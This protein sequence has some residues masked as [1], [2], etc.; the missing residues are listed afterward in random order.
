MHVWY[1]CMVR[2]EYMVCM[3]VYVCMY[4]M[5]PSA[6]HLRCICHKVEMSGAMDCLPYSRCPTP[7][8]KNLHTYIHTY[9]EKYKIEKIEEEKIMY[10]RKHV[11][12]YISMHG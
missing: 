11:C 7:P 4:G 8:R 10:V 12:M 5:Y 9:I 6:L 1:V 3:Y 2:Y